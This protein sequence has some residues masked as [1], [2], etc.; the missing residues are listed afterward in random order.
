MVVV[1]SI[2]NTNE[3]HL[4]ED[5][6]RHVFACYRVLGNSFLVTAHLVPGVNEMECV[7]CGGLLY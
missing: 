1:Y 3:E 6:C 7:E 4:L 5:V 2:G